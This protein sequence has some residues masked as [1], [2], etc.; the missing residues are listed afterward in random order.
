MTL[1]TI[2]FANGFL[3]AGL[4]SFAY[5]LATVALPRRH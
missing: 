4:G 3:Y 2:I 1:G 5:F